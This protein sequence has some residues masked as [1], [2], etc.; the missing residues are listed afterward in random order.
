MNLKPRI[1][2]LLDGASGPMTVSELVER[3]DAPYAMILEA[4]EALSDRGLI[5][6]KPYGNQGK[7]VSLKPSPTDTQPIKPPANLVPELMITIQVGRDLND[8]GY[9]VAIDPPGFWQG[10]LIEG[11]GNRDHVKATVLA[12]VRTL[13][14]RFVG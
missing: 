8:F 4:I 5:D 13:L 14:R 12:L 2:Q 11:D 3:V 7:L 6:I 10:D 9:T 1:L